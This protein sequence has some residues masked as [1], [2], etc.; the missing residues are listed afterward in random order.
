MTKQIYYFNPSNYYTLELIFIH[1]N[2]PFV[3]VTPQ[4]KHKVAK[5]QRPSRSL[6]NFCGTSTPHWEMRSSLNFWHYCNFYKAEQWWKSNLYSNSNKFFYSW[7]A[8][9]YLAICL[10]SLKFIFEMD[11]NAALEIIKQSSQ[12]NVMKTLGIEIV[13]AEKNL[14]VLSMNIRHYWK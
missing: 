13:S 9:A 1:I 2:R 10:I 4:E 11:E 12:H 8:V 14:V 3:D 7:W 5:K 6:Y